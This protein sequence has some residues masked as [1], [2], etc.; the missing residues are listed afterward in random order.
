MTR[1]RAGTGVVLALAVVGAT[2]A[3]LRLPSAEGPPAAV[4]PIDTAALVRTTLTRTTQLSGTLGYAG[5][6]ALSAQLQGTVT[7]LPVPGS[8]VHRGQRIY[9][10][11]GQGVFLFLGPRPA[12]RPFQL[13]MTDGPD[14]QQLE[15]NLAELGFG[16][17]LTV[18]PRYTWA[19]ERAILRWQ[20]ATGQ[21]QTGQVELGRVA[22]APTDLRIEAAVA[23]L[24]APSQP[25]QPIVTASSPTPLVTVAVPPTQTYLVH[26]GDRVEVILPSGA[27]SPG[28]VVGISSVAQSSSDHQTR[29]PSGAPDASVPAQVTLDRRGA[30]AGLDQ[31]PVSV[32]VTDQK[33]SNVLAAPVTALVAIPGGGYA[34]WLD[35]PGAARRLVTVTPGLFTDTLVQI[36]GPGLRAGDRVEVPAQ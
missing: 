26:A 19:T 8:V 34:V 5:S 10:V 18:D 25:G 33:A 1:V 11:D 35:R 9:E 20:Q 23:T 21:P 30:A 14:V 2:A 4:V 6:Y 24:G 22:F 16:T 32:T 13:G 31:T 17:E 12:W 27:T 3:W 7:A 28:R 36:T 29:G 15:S